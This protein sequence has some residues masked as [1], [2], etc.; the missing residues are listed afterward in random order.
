MRTNCTT[1]PRAEG[2][3][4]RCSCRD[5]GWAARAARL[6]GRH[7]IGSPSCPRST[8]VRP[9]RSI[10]GDGQAPLAD[11]G[12]AGSSITRLRPGSRG[13]ARVR[14]S[15]PYPKVRCGRLRSLFHRHQQGASTAMVQHAAL[16]QPRETKALA[17][18]RGLKSTSNLHAEHMRTRSATP[19]ALGQSRR[20]LGPSYVS[21][22]ES[23]THS[24]SRAA[25]S[26]SANHSTTLPSCTGSRGAAPRP[27]DDRFGHRMDC[28]A[29]RKSNNHP[30]H[31]IVKR[32][33]L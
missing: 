24:I 28:L 27:S 3:L 17:L 29:T 19:S 26:S 11:A 33:V 5:P 18:G 30:M 22:W 32:E 25:K 7:C 1:R 10:P 23:A 4:I 15:Q 14:R 13:F 16:R 12:L 31:S 2:T 21:I 6:V 9:S 20:S 8:S